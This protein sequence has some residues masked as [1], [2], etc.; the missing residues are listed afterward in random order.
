MSERPGKSR[1][2]DLQEERA[3]NQ[4]DGQQPAQSSVMVAG[5]EVTARVTDLSQGLLAIFGS[6]GVFYDGQA[7][8]VE[9]LAP[10]MGATDSAA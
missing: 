10:Y 5:Q 1:L 7:V 3:R 8:K 9:I 6:I 2:L 4:G